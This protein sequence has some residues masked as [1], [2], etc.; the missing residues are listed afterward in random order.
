MLR[1]LLPAVPPSDAP[2]WKRVLLS[3]RDD[4]VLDRLTLGVRA[5]LSGGERLAIRRDRDP[6]RHRR[7]AAH[8]GLVLEGPLVDP[9]ETRRGNR[10]GRPLHRIV[11]AIEVS[12]RFGVCLLPL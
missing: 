10:I 6:C 1:T 7:F 8:L 11:L 2:P 4:H 12:D 9:F 3:V 5:G